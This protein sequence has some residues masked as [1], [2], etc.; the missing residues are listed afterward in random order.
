M[1][2]CSVP[3][4]AVAIIHDAESHGILLGENVDI[5]DSRLQLQTTDI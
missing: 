3:S 2:S 1:I 4:I 5:E